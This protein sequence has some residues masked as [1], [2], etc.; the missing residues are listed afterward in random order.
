MPDPVDQFLAAFEDGGADNGFASTQPGQDPPAEAA[1]DELPDKYKGKTAEE[2]YALM[3]QEQQFNSQRQQQQG[4]K[5]EVEVPPFDRGQSVS[6]YGEEFTTAFEASGL[7]PFELDARVRAGESIPDE[8]IGAYAA[9]LKIP[10]EVIGHYVRSFAPQQGQQQ[11]QQQA[12]DAVKERLVAFLGGAEQAQALSQWATDNVPPG[13]IQA[14]NDHVAAGRA[15]EA[16]EFLRGLWER[17]A[18]GAAPQNPRLIR[19]DAPGGGGDTFSSMDEVEA[20]L[21]KRNPATGQRLYEVD[22]RYRKAHDL[23]VLRSAK[24]LGV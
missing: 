18:K 17:R 14:F 12:P 23:K 20:S 5:T 10:A 21:Y 19:G 13:E 2:V 24:K 6:V 4:Q 9:A 16:E 1:A 22:S 15:K 3:R 8:T 11:G 7:N